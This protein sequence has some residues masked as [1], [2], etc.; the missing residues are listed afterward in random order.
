MAKIT[1]ILIGLLFS[2]SFG[3]PTKN[4]S[5]DTCIEK[6]DAEKILGL[7]ASQTESAT[8]NEKNVVQHKCSWKATQD[9]LNS[10][11]YYI[12]EQHDNAESAHK[13]FEDI[14]ISNRNNSG[15]SHPDIGDEA[16]LHSDG[17]NFCLLMVR[18][19]NRIIRMKVNR[20]TN[21]TSVDEMKRVATA[22]R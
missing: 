11:L 10:S 6:V 17:T 5:D 4:Y 18:K 12:D 7:P 3:W 21:E 9:D 2:S 16:W 8:V 15:Q 22:W 20:L 14:V 1:F 19:G 13:V